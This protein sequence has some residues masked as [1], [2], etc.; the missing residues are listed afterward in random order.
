MQFGVFI[1]RAVDAN[2]QAVRLELVQVRLKI[3]AG[4]AIQIFKIRSALPWAS[5]SRSFSLSGAVLRNDTASALSANGSST[6]KR[7]LS[8]PIVERAHTSDAC[9][10]TPL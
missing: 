6:E 8:I 7:M 10:K 1:D 3:E 9:S 5:F 4:P 2:E